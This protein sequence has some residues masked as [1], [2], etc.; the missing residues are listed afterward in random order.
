[1]PLLRA[2]AFASRNRR[3]DLGRSRRAPGSITPAWSNRDQEP[4]SSPVSPT[5]A[6]TL[7]TGLGNAV[8]YGFSTA[9]PLS[10]EGLRSPFWILVAAK[11][12]HEITGPRPVVRVAADPVNPPLLVAMECLLS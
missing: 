6:S 4:S 7:V 1:M 9:A 8:S 12:E 5:S 11:A 2:D 3:V 10:V